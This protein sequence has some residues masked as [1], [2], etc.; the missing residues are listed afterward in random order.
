MAKR[1]DFSTGLKILDIFFMRNIASGIIYP[2]DEIDFAK[3]DL[4]E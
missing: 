3:G 4:L 1:P 2:L